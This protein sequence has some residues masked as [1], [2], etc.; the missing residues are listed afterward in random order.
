M[1]NLSFINFARDVGKRYRELYDGQGLCQKKDCQ[2]EK[3][4]HLE[5]YQLIQGYDFYHLHKEYNC[6][7]QWEVQTREISQPELN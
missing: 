5:S 6:L 4:C 7:L 1:K 3:E 2:E